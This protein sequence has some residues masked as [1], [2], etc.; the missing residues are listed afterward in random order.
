MPWFAVRLGL[1]AAAVLVTSAPSHAFAPTQHSAPL[2]I[3]GLPQ[4]RVHRATARTAPA[5]A[6]A[7]FAPLAQA[8]WR[9]SWD[10][11]TGVPVRITGSF[12]DAPGAVADPAIA[13]RVARTFL[14]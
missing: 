14:A 8:G 1:V 2:T 9:A 4:P 7:A 13:E 11:D 12:I 10:A 6:R 5:A 3:L